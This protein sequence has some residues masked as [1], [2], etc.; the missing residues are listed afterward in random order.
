VNLIAALALYCAALGGDIEA[1]DGVLH[2]YTH[3]NKPPYELV[4]MP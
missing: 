1:V 2:C 3:S 4:E